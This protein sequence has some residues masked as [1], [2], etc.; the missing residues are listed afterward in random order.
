[1][2]G[3]LIFSEIWDRPSKLVIFINQLGLQNF[4]EEE[5]EIR[6]RAILEVLG[7]PKEHVEESLKNYIEE[8]E[9]DT[10]IKI[11]K[12]EIVEAQ[13]R[14]DIQEGIKFYSTFAE[15]EFVTK[16]I[17]G[18]SSF[19]FNYMPSS[20]EIIEPEH[21]VLR[22]V[23]FSDILNDLQARSHNVDKIAKELGSEN[24]FLK[25]NM[26]TL[27][28][29]SILISLKINNL[30]AINLSKATG[31]EEKELE[32]LL[33]DLTKENKIEKEGDLYC[34]KQT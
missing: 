30:T 4:M 2:R 15:I 22:N 21:I 14:K 1:M 27:L 13:E 17:I 16:K 5:K 32:P 8:I 23:E 24:E 29:N 31:I 28:K 18:I 19:C 33:E 9:K 11:V 12:K 20:I 25:R 26:K 6:C 3:Y 7:K 34:L 10:T